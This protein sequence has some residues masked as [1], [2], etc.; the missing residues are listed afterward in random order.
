MGNGD[1]VRRWA[2]TYA[3]CF[4]R[5]RIS[6]SASSVDSGT[7]RRCTSF[8]QAITEV[9]NARALGFGSRVGG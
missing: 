8:S 1:R 9:I 5:D 4:G 2:R 7:T 6:F 3:S